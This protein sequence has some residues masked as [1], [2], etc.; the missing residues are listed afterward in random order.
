MDSITVKNFRCFKEA[1]P[2]RL[3]PLTF[4]VGENSTG[5]TSFLA[6][7]RALRDVAYEQVVP[8]FKEEPYDLGSFD[9]IVHK[10]DGRSESVNEF[11]AG[12]RITALA[13]KRNVVR[14]Q[15]Q[16]ATRNNI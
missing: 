6:L 9:E 5:K 12:F 15:V 13:N 3:A 16:K 4:L 7:I 2:I 14:E 10:G 1:G 11:K 8:D